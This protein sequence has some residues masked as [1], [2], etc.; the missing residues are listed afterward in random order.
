MTTLSPPI[1]QVV[2]CRLSCCA[3]DLYVG[4]DISPPMWA[5]AWVYVSHQLGEVQRVCGRDR[6]LDRSGD[7][8]REDGR[9]DPRDGSR[10]AAP[11]KG[12]R[13]PQI[14]DRAE[15]PA[16]AHCD[17]GRCSGRACFRSR[18]G[19]PRSPRGR[20]QHRARPRTEWKTV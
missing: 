18:S 19:W 15:G 2:S 14:G 10:A 9:T 4:R 8:R 16:T 12:A 11:R 6:A 3:K 20:S 13:E 5:N 17:E 7:R 1:E